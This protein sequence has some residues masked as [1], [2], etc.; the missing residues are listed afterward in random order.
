MTDKKLYIEY[1]LYFSP[2]ANQDALHEM[3]EAFQENI[4]DV[5][6]NAYDHGSALDVNDI[7]YEVVMVQ[8]KESE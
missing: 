4:Y 3:A 8:T 5:W 2:Q 7:T 6:N 1:R